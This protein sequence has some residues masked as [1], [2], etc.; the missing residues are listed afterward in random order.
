MPDRPPSLVVL[1]PVFNDWQAASLLIPRVVKQLEREGPIGVLVVDDGS[2]ETCSLTID[3]PTNQVAWARVL[4]LRR[5]LGHQRAIAVGLSYIDEHLPCDAAIIMDADGE[6][7][8]EDLLLLVE[9]YHRETHSP[10]VFAERSRRLESL[11][12]RA[13]YAL[14]RLLH[15]TLTG[16]GVSVGNFSVLP[17]ERLA[18][19]V[20]VSELWIHYAAA[21]VRSR[22][23]IV[24]VP[25]P[26]G[27][28]LVST[29]RMSF[30]ALV[31]HGLSAISVYSDVVFTRL[32]VASTT[33]ALLALSGM[34]IVLGIRLFSTLA[35]PG[36]T[37]F[38]LAVLLVVLLQAITF[39]VSLTF[40]VLGSR[41]HAEVIPRRDYAH[42][43]AGVRDISPPSSAG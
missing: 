32:I 6:D 35:I 31:V 28:R 13:F 25:A 10:I 23:P 17:R 42:F 3:A 4:R 37:S 36:W 34:G 27:R 2:T 21:A 7:R 26:R 41:R 18:S 15:L 24:T 16:R 8:P 30:T 39:V 22:Q 19:L 33:L 12:F 9:R 11:T 5:N 43:V 20:V 38:V 1:L 29:S 40:M 14:Y